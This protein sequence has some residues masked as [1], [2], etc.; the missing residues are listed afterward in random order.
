MLAVTQVPGIPGRP[1]VDTV[2]CSKVTI[3]WAAPDSHGGSKITHYVIH[4]GTA[5]MDLESFVKRRITGRKTRCTISS[6]IRRNKEY[7]FAVAAENTEGVG[8]LSEFSEWIKMQTRWGTCFSQLR[9]HDRLNDMQFLLI[10]FSD[11]CIELFILN[12]I[13][14][15]STV[16]KAFSS[17]IVPSDSV[18]ITSMVIKTHIFKVSNSC[19]C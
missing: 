5:D 19:I 10:L 2:S 3:H 18:L 6:Q 13:N 14:F 16:C 17:N 4:Y 12:L 11:N 8:P 1:V 9:I 7:K 15:L